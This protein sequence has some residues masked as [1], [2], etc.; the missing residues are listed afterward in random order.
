[1]SKVTKVGLLSK[2]FLF[3]FV[4][5]AISLGST[6]KTETNFVRVNG[7]RFEVNGKPYYFVGTNFWYGLNLGSKGAGGDRKRLLRELDKLKAM[8]VTNLRIMAASEGPDTE[9]WRM[10]PA[11]QLSLIHI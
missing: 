4:A 7:T 10:V 5:I 9:P 11:L 1:M 6:T 2:K 3:L 8:G